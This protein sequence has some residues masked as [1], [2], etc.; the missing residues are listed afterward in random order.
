MYKINCYNFFFN[1]T[2][3]VYKRSLS[4]A[5]ILFKLPHARLPRVYCRKHEE[6]MMRTVQA[7]CLWCRLL[8]IERSLPSEVLSWCTEVS[9][10]QIWTFR[11]WKIW[12]P[13]S[14]TNFSLWAEF[15]SCQTAGLSWC[16][17]WLIEWLAAD[18]FGNLVIIL[19]LFKSKLSDSS[20]FCVNILSGFFTP[21][22]L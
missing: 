13:T 5:L 14:V 1:K 20:Y 15:Q 6:Q 9:L 8:L 18:H 3:N 7:E 17:S 16:V 11:C 2:F 22:W 4:E 21:L 19:T 10:Q 12:M